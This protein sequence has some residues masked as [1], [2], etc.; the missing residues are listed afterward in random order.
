[1]ETLVEFRILSEN[2][3]QEVFTE[4]L[5]AFL[6]QLHVKF[7]TARKK[8]LLNRE[9]VQQEI[10]KGILP[11]FPAE[12][13][14]IRNSEWKCAELPADLQ[15]RRVEITGPVDRKMIINALNSGASCFMADFEDSTSPTW[16][17]V[18]EGQQNL[19]DAVSKTISYTNEKGKE[20]KLNTETAVLM[21]RPRG[22]HLQEKHL[23]IDGE[24]ASGALMDFGIFFFN[25]AKNLLEQGSRPYFYLPKLEH[26]KEARWWNDVFVFA[27][28]YLGIPQRSIRATVLIE[29]INASFQLDEILYELK[30]HSLGLN[31]G[32]WDYIFS[33]IKKFRN[34]P[35]FVLPDRAQVTMTSPFM[36]AYSQR[37]IEV[38][39][40]RGVFAIGGMAA[41]IPVKNDAEKK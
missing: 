31:C 11:E 34:H 26:Y 15:D 17:N 33:F 3:Y 18:V 8:L 29:T 21:V 20:Y 27:Q 24:E 13:Y 9:I 10:D 22:L 1:M 19:S 35:E 14:E 38:C 36:S 32:R 25:N 30:D 12:T 6:T 40:R 4:D 41:Q 37:V 23:L 2:R 39:H 28:E 7:N 16:E 5:V